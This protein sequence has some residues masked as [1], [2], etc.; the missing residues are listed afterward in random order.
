[1]DFISKLTSQGIGDKASII[2]KLVLC[3]IPVNA[4]E[5]YK[6]TFALTPLILIIS[7][8]N[9]VAALYGA[10]VW[11]EDGPGPYLNN[12]VKD[13]IF[14]NIN[15]LSLNRD[16][17]I[18]VSL[19]LYIEAIQNRQEANLN[20]IFFLFLAILH[21]LPRLVQYEGYLDDKNRHPLLNG[22]RDN[23]IRFA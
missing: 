13:F 5:P 3:P 19:I 12:L 11:L 16:K 6:V 22:K 17:L 9:N 2:D 18:H 23:H 15:Y 4:K 8:L 1:M 20:H 7:F 21:F 14:Y 10:I